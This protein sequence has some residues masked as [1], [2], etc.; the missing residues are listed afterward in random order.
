MG[1]NKAGG[2]QGGSGLPK[3]QGGDGFRKVG[4]VG[5]VKSS[6]GSRRG[7]CLGKTQ[8]ADGALARVAAFLRPW[9]YNDEHNMVLALVDFIVQ[10]RPRH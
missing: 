10:R 6:D 7:V 8:A 5:G 1:V 9:E 3:A 2:E 4:V